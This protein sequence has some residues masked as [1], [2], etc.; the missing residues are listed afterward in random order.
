MA[1]APAVDLE[2]RLAGA[3]RADAAAECVRSAPTC[4][5]AAAGCTR[6]APAP[7]AASPRA[8]ARDGR[9]C[10]GST[11]CG[12]RR[13]PSGPSP[14]CAPARGSDP[15]RRSGAR[16]SCCSDQVADLLALALAQEGRRVDR[17]APLDR[18]AA[19]DSRRRCRR[20]A[21]ARRGSPRSPL[22]SSPTR[23]AFSSLAAVLCGILGISLLLPVDGTVTRA[24]RRAQSRPKSSTRPTR[25]TQRKRTGRKLRPVRDPR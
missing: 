23:T 5:S 24:E 19:D 17:R 14:D 11:R 25:R 12:R 18:G 15:R 16:A 22:V 20:G 13:G 3:A 2:L 8:C 6:A 21:P 1:D 9:R 4:G 7:P 10:R